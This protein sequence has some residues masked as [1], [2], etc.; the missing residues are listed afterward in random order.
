M[1]SVDYINRIG[2]SRNLLN[3]EPIPISSIITWQLNAPAGTYPILL[4]PSPSSPYEYSVS[5][6]SPPLPSPFPP[7]Q[8]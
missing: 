1:F 7:L 5:S 8:R 4:L 6:L 2:L 3:P